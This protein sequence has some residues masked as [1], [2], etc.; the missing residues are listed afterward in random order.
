MPDDLSALEQTIRQQ[1]NRYYGKYRAFV[2]DNADPEKLGRCRLTIPSV[3]GEEPSDWALPCLPYGGMAD[4]GMVAVPPIDAQVFA[5]FVEGDI[6]A[7]VWTGT[8]YQPDVAPPAEFAANDEP[9]AKVIKTESG[10]V[11]VLEDKAGEEAV[12]L[13]SSAGAVVEL[14]PGGSL[15]LTDSNGA[16]VVIDAEAG[17]IRIEDANGNSLTMAAGGIT[18]SD[19]SG[20]EI[21]T[22]PS[23]IDVKGAMITIEGQS[24]ALGGAGGEPLIKG[25]SFMAIFNAHTHVCA[26]PGSP[27]G[28]PLPPMTPA[29][30][31]IKTTAS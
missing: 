18:A 17:E 12:T 30:T 1:Q 16:T 8:F 3:L 29:Q 28:P 23:G 26:L 15:A 7:P 10:H 9:T 6:S 5:E 14:N 27:S 2:V 13:T 22:G 4:I 31:T 24:V 19:A 25:Q 20:N 21:A 11:L